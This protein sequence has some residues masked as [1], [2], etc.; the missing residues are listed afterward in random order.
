MPIRFTSTGINANDKISNPTRY[1]NNDTLIFTYDDTR[2][3]KIDADDSNLT[4]HYKFDG[5][6]NDS[7]SN[8]Y[9][10]TIGGGTPTTTNVEKVI[11]LSGN[12]ISN[13]AYLTTS[14]FSLGNRPFSVSFWVKYGETSFSNDYFFVYQ[15]NWSSSSNTNKVIV[16]GIKSSKQYAWIGYSNDSVTTSSFTENTT[17]WVHLVYSVD[18][19]Y[20]RYIY[21][22]GVEILKDTTKTSFVLPPDSENVNI[23]WWNKYQRDFKGYMDDLRFYDKAL[24]Q[25]EINTLYN[26]NQTPYTLTFDNPTECDIL[27]VGGGGGGGTS[28]SSTSSVPGAGGGAGGLIFL[29]NLTIPANTYQIKVGKGGDGDIHTDTSYQRG[30]NGYNSSFS[31]LQTEAIGGGGGA[32]TEGTVAGNSGGSGGG[33][34]L[35]VEAAQAG[36]TGYVSDIF[37]NDG[38]ILRSNYIQGYNGGETTASSQSGSEPY[39]GGGGGAG[40][41]GKNNIE[42]GISDDG[43]GGDGISGISG[44][45]AIDFKNHFGITNTDIGEHHT[46]GK[47]YF[48]GGGGTGYRNGSTNSSTGG[49]GGGGDSTT[50]NGENGKSNTGGGGS[51]GRASES[52]GRWNGG[53]GG[54]GI[55]I[56]KFKQNFEKILQ[57]PDNLSIVL[58]NYNINKYYNNWIT[59]TTDESIYH[60]G[61]NIGIG[62]DNPK[63][64]LDVIGGISATIKNFKIEH[65]LDS[66]MVLY[67]TS[68]EAP[69]YDNIYRGKKIIKNGYGEVNIDKE[70]NTTGGMLEGTFKKLNKNYQLYLRNNETYDG[71]RGY[72]EDNLLKIFCENN[73]N[74]TI[75]WLV[76]GERNDKEILNN[77]KCVSGSLLCEHKNNI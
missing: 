31:Y 49:L 45:D 71:V 17:D 14:A 62:T 38:T 69:R 77:N 72:I 25:E 46:D 70:C 29:Q 13:D 27:I 1:Y 76:I 66:N 8:G 40:E 55:V 73:E 28:Y 18:E 41:A 44:I 39:S 50:G 54:S 74:I 23:G 16:L 37:K 42:S 65:P 32:S 2:Y 63:C 61:N 75:D 24:S 30:K 22:N 48:A 12:F 11:G 33:S 3:P 67:H 9:N 15:G 7:S 5:D 34:V 68:L 51:G 26:V 6:F 52:A 56:I 43:D 59:N 10:L 64:L 53:N 58:K 47:V 4:A 35:N 19:D 57:N 21:R 60:L 36:G 20:T